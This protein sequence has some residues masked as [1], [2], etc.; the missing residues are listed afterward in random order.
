MKG[1]DRET[2]GTDGAPAVASD[3]RRVV[4][5][6]R[7][8]AA[9]RQDRARAFGSHVRGYTVDSDE[10]TALMER[11]RRGALRCFVLIFVPILVLPL[12]FAA[13]SDLATMRLGPLPPLA[14]LVLGPVALG[15]I[16]V[17]AA[18]N[19]RIASRR[20]DRWVQHRSAQDS[21]DHDPAADRTQDRSEDRR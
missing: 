21:A 10:V 3:G 14:W 12:V 11:Q 18:I 20:E 8:E 7:T 15:A 2:A 19:D 9:R 17:T 4:L 16:V 6:P 13:D 1:T 5:H